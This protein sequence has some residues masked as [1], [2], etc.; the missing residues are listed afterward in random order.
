[1]RRWTNPGL[2]PYPQIDAIATA[3]IVVD[4]AGKRLFDEGFGG[5]SFTNDLARLDDPVCATVV[6]DAPIWKT[7]W[8]AAQIPPNPQ[9]LAGNLQQ[10]AW[11]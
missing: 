3:A 8:K 9:L 10:Y 4:P 11:H 6:C 7:A 2:W 1:M 5:I